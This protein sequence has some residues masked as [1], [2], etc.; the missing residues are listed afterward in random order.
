MNIIKEF[1]IKFINHFRPE[2]FSKS[3]GL[4]I[5][6][7][8]NVFSFPKISKS[9]HAVIDKID[10]DRLNCVNIDGFMFFITIFYTY[11]IKNAPYIPDKE[12]M[13]ISIVHHKREEDNRDSIKVKYEFI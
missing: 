13:D 4:T 1:N 12:L 11:L 5:E 8:I 2:L 7:V 6:D 10:D 9:L 3:S